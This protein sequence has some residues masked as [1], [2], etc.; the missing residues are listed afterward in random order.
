MRSRLSWTG[1][2]SRCGAGSPIG[3]RNSFLAPRRPGIANDREGAGSVEQASRKSRR[4]HSCVLQE[5]E[6]VMTS[7]IP[8]SAECDGTREIII[9]CLREHRDFPSDTINHLSSCD[10]CWS[11]FDSFEAGDDFVPSARQIEEGEPQGPG[12]LDMPRGP[13]LRRSPCYVEVTSRGTN[14]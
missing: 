1:T 12:S 8:S 11:L 5:L 13:L 4:L 2:R 9:H 14:A 3:Y 6:K 7:F 10:E